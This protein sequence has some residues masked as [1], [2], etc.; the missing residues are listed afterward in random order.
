MIKYKI[1]VKRDLRRVNSLSWIVAA[2]MLVLSIAGLVIPEKMYPSP[3]EV[4]SYLTND[5]VNLL[6][7]LPILIGSMWLANIGHLIGFL[8]WPGAVV[9]SLYNYLA[10]LLGILFGFTSLF[11]LLIVGICVY[12]LVDLLTLINEGVVQDQLMGKVP[13]RLGGWFSLVF[14]ILFLLL[15]TKGLVGHIGGTQPLPMA[16]VGLMIADLVLSVVMIS[17]SIAT[18]RRSPIGYVCGTGLLFTYLMLFVGVFI[19]MLIQPAILGMDLDVEGLV[20]IGGMTLVV[21]VPFGLFV[22]GI[23]NNKG[24]EDG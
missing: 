24:K 6:L 13:L 22:N 14:S 12:L 11:Y 1:P 23:L 9:Y 3:D 21:S 17:G 8:F 20:M 10:Y 18:I 15:A 7:G 4:Q 16:E 19:I 5:V 2:L